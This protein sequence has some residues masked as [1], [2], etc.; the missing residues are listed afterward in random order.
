[1]DIK[2][3]VQ[4]Q[5]G[6]HSNA[7]VTSTSHRKGGD[8]KKLV[9]LADVTG[10]EEVLDI[11]TGGGHTA[12]ALAPLVHKVTA[13]DLTS[14]MLSAAEQFI[15]ENG[16]DNVAFIE[17]DAEQLPFSDES[18]DLVTCRIAPHH[19]PNVER[20]ITEVYRVLSCGGRFLLDDNVAPEDDAF[21]HFYNTIEKKRDASHYR[22]WKKTEWLRMLELSGFEIDEVHRFDKSFEFASWCQRMNVSEAD[23][24]ALNDY[25]LE[26]PESVKH[27]FRFR[28][29]NDQ[30]MISFQGQAIVLKA[31]KP[32]I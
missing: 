31:T 10:N 14:K 28:T 11:A 21:D 2:K 25:M 29:N 5:F 19:F 4:K 32:L 26:V 12:N 27:Q 9:D 8:L 6:S 23:Q 30:Q 24:K 1:M 15:K 7:Y 22:A 3:Q 18:F 20:F 16:H 13:L 17:G